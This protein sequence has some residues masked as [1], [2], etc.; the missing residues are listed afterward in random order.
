MTNINKTNMHK[1][2]DSI[3]KA[4]DN[5]KELY[6]IFTK[7]DTAVFMIDMLDDF[8]TGA[9]GNK[10]V[11]YIIEPM[12]EFLQNAKKNNVVVNAVNDAH[13]EESIEFET[14]YKH[15]IIGT[16]GA[17]IIADLREIEFDN[18]F[19]K[20][21][22]NGFHNQDVVNWLNEN[23]QITKIVVIGVLTD[24]CVFQFALNLKT[25]CNQINRHMEVIIPTNLVETSEYEGHNRELFS[26]MSLEF[27]RQAGINVVKEVNFT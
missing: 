6:T 5:V 17:N 12:K 27:M 1:A 19:Y 13:T 20:N 2:L 23:K 15:S 26:Y 3:V 14:F 11:D 21:S 22:T 4:V 8:H 7:G 10:Y 25:Y 18:V 16:D 24:M 9:L